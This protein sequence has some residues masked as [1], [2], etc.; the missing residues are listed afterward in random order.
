MADLRIS[1]LPV[2][3]PADLDDI[4]QIPLSDVSA[5]ET[6]RLD[7]KDLIEVGVSQLIDNA[8]IPGAKIVTDSLTAA[9]IAA[10]AI[11]ASELANN[12]VDTAAVINGAITNA[13][14]STG[15]DGAK[16]SAGT[17]ANAAL[18]SGIDGAK[19]A[20]DSVTARQIAANAVGASEL[21]N[22]SVDTAAIQNNAVTNA[23]VAS[24][25]DGAKLVAD[26]VT[27]AQIAANAVGASELANNAVDTAALQNNSVTDAKISTGINGGKLS[28]GTVANAALAAGIDGAKLVD[29]SVTALQIGANAIGA[30]ELANNSV[31][32]NA[33]QAGAVTDAKLATGIDGAKLQDDSV[34]AQQIAPDAVGPSELADNSV[35]TAAVQNGAVT[36]DKLAAGIDG[37]KLTA[38]TVVNAALAT[39]IDGAKLVDGSVTA[40]QI[41][42]DAVGA[43]ELAN[44]SVDTAA[45]QAGAITDAKLATGIDG[46]KLQAGSVSS[47]AIAA[48]AIGASQLADDSVDTAAVQN[49]AITDAK[50]ASGIDG[51]KLTAGTV[52]N[53]KLAAGI[54]GAKLTNNSITAAK[55]VPNA[56]GA[57]QLANNSVDNAA[58]IDGA[59]TNVKLATGI[60]GG[61]LLAG[62]VASAAIA[63]NAI[64]D[65]QLADNSVDTAAVQSN[66]ITDDKLATG[67]SGSKINSLPASSLA[68]VTDRGLDQSTGNIG[69]TNTIT[70]GTRS[71]ISF[72]AQGHITGVANLQPGD[73]PN[74]TQTTTG[75]V[76]VPVDSGLTVAGDGSLDHSNNIRAGALSGISYDEHGHIISIQP[77]I[78]TDLPVATDSTIGGVSV[79]TGQGLSLAGSGALTHTTS[80]IAPGDYAK[81]R[82]DENGHA[83][84][85]M[86]LVQADIPALDA[87]KLTTGTLNPARIANKSIEKEK[88]ANYSTVI[89]QEAEPGNGDFTGQ[90]WYKES[91]AQL[92]T[93]SG[94]SWIPVGFGRLSEENLRFC[95]TFD[96]ST[97]DVLQLTP[98]GVTA[99]LTPGSSIP[100]A[101]DAL[102]GVYLVCDKPG[103]YGGD[104]YDEGDWVLCLGQA[105]GWARIDTLSGS[106]A[107]VSLENLIDTTITA[108]ASGDTLIFDGTTNKWVNNPT[109]AQKASFVEAIDGSLT[110]FTL[111]RDGL[112]ANNLLISLG[113]ILQEPG[114]D[115]TFTAPRTVNFSTAPPPGI[116]HWILIE[117]VT[118]TGGGGGGGTTLPDGT[119]AD[120]YLQWSSAL[121]AWQPSKVLN[122]GSF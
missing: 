7:A 72:D 59:I 35:D 111:S 118:S 19:L 4:D 51:G 43:S 98:F 21:A 84:V 53:A 29:G 22:N 1:E 15:I 76:K 57:S 5:S 3:K 47:A 30:S 100:P 24:G 20:D 93:W 27:A 16:L 12:A 61:K 58:V 62:T 80:P 26:S 45:V 41:G 83:I 78:G 11:G 121:S 108:P 40:L 88:L 113:G 101:S 46:G 42:P 95:G 14:L 18:A 63:A 122:G 36:D 71:G 38:G 115:F 120:E 106:G 117:G 33:I 2:L 114:V 48:N 74:A 116:D 37:G 102:T 49:G 73:L 23:K 104:T 79:P 91:D 6:R 67:I 8:T 66:A 31:D 94:N 99:G 81:L 105:Q 10:N 92:R 103:T 87:S 60:H 9:Q 107:T 70:A 28:A 55:I 68:T 69:H 17:V 54:D 85:G 13:K 86:A 44:N 32:V 52:D 82:I 50:L 112:S 89:I 65:S 97:G 34:T 75:V 109:A 96:A 56:I 25:I 119:A 64:T 110:S 39:G 90:F 77:L